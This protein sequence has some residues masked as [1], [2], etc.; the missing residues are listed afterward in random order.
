MGVVFAVVALLADPAMT[1]LPP[2]SPRVDETSMEEE[3]GMRTLRRAG[4]LLPTGVD[5]GDG[6]AA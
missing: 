5:S 1:L 4:L 6:V 3:D 2:I